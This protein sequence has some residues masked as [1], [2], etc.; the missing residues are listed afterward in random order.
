MDLTL[1]TTY[2]LMLG[3]TLEIGTVEHPYLNKAV[4]TLHGDRYDTIHLPQVGTK[5]IAAMNSQR[6]RMNRPCVIR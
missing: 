4:V 5:M 1:D 3:G 2:F 6:T